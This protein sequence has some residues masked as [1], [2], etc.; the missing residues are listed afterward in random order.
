MLRYNIPRFGSPSLEVQTSDGYGEERSQNE[1]ECRQNY[2]R[3][4]K[5]IMAVPEV[6]P[7]EGTHRFGFSEHLNLLLDVTVLRTQ[8]P[9]QRP[10][11]RAEVVDPDPPFRDSLVKEDKRQIEIT[12]LVRE[13]KN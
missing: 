12:A 8:H 6:I 7:Q 3:D 2:G 5:L 1:G 10:R 4:V 9:I 11:C 13:E